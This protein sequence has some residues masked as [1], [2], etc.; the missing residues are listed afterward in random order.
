MLDLRSLKRIRVLL[1]LPT[2]LLA[3]TG[4]NVVIFTADIQS[5]V[6]CFYFVSAFV[7]SYSPHILAR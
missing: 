7:H 1:R 3:T 2:Q 6:F 4:V 5:F